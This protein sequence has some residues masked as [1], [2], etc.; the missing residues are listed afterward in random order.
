MLHIIKNNRLYTSSN[1]SVLKGIPN[2]YLIRNAGV[3]ANPFI[4]YYKVKN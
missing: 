2:C 3:P 4:V 1:Q